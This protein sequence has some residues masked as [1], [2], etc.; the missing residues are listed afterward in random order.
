MLAIILILAMRNS[1]KITYDKVH[2][3]QYSN[4]IKSKI[5]RWSGHIHHSKVNRRDKLT[6]SSCGEMLGESLVDLGDDAR[7]L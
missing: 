7:I 6:Q 3:W 5:I 1:K 4:N 2:S